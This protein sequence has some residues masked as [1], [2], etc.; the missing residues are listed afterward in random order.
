MS[1]ISEIISNLPSKDKELLDCLIKVKE[2]KKNELIF[3]QSAPDDRIFYVANGLLRKYI[4]KNEKEKTLDFYFTDEIYFPQILIENKKTNCVLQALE[5]SSVFILDNFEFE[6]IKSE[7]VSLLKLEN[8]ILEYAFAQTNERLQQ[9]QTMNATER[10]L[11]LLDRNPIIVQRI[12]LTYI[13]SYLGINNAS[14][15]KI[16]GA[17]K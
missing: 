5:K 7:S 13:S 14:L 15:S 11:N 4:L 3:S 6:K 8:T 9:F 17:I 1:K 12:S 10:Y 16:R 2:Y